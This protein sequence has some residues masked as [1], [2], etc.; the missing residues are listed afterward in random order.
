MFNGDNKTVEIAKNARNT[1]MNLAQRGAR[2]VLALN[3][4]DLSEAPGVQN[5]DRSGEFGKLI[6]LLISEAN[7]VLFHSFTTGCSR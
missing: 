3:L 5:V 4:I 6:S 7:T 2:R 1:I